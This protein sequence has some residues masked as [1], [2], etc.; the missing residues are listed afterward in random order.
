MRHFLSVASALALLAGA[1]QAFASDVALGIKGGTQGA[2]VELTKGL[3]EKLNLRLDLN[4]YSFDADETYDGN[5]YELDLDLRMYGL[6]LDWHPFG[7]GFRMTAGVYNNGMELEGNTTGDVTI[8]GNTQSTT[9]NAKVDFDSMAPY[10]GI[11]WGNAVSQ[12]KRLGFNVNLGMV[13]T[14]SPNVTLSES[15]G[16]FTAQEL[17]EEERRLEDEID[18]FEYYPVAN[19]GLSYRF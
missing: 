17:R 15:G 9:L 18:D 1:G 13:F 5:D 8:D 14:G 11:G 19:I 2:G 6:Q 12:D 7:G 3:T 10:V 16:A 4:G